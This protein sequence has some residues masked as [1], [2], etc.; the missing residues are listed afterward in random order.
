M[1]KYLL[2]LS[3]ALGSIFSTAKVEENIYNQLLSK[4]TSASLDISLLLPFSSPPFSPVDQI[5]N[6]THARQGPYC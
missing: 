6:L 2:G 5:E 4:Q 1:V 3:E